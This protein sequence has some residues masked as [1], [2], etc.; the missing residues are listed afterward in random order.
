MIKFIEL[1]NFIIKRIELQDE[2]FADGDGIRVK[3]H[4]THSDFVNKNHSWYTAKMLKK[5]A[6]TLLTP[7]AKPVV[8]NHSRDQRDTIGRVHDAKFITSPG[9]NGSSGYI[10]ALADIWGY[11]H[12]KKVENKNYLTVSI[13]LS[14]TAKTKITCNICGEDITGTQF[15]HA[16]QRGEIYDKKECYWIFDNEMEIDHIAFVPE[17]ADDY[18][19][20]INDS[21]QAEAISTNHEVSSEIVHIEKID[22]DK[23]ALEVEK[24]EEN[25]KAP[26]I[27]E[28]K[29]EEPIVENKDDTECWNGIEE[30][31]IKEIIRLDTLLS[32][33]DKLSPEK[34]KQL[35]DSVF[36]GPHR[37]FPIDT[38]DRARSALRLLPKSTFGEST[39]AKI[40]TCII[41]KQKALKCGIGKTKDEITLDE[42]LVRDDINNYINTNYYL[43]KDIDTVGNNVAKSIVADLK[44]SVDENLK[45]E[46]DA[47][48]NDYT[49]LVDE[50]LDLVNR[51][52]DER[53]KVLQLIKLIANADIKTAE[54]ISITNEEIENFTDTVKKTIEANERNPITD[55][56]SQSPA[57][58]KKVD[59]K[60][61]EEEDNKEKE[62]KIINIS[63]LSQSER[64][65]ILTQNSKTN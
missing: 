31:D 30:K 36:C 43:K 45:A 52:F 56:I 47:I 2:K 19:M 7:F 4:I 25:S 38:C 23:E 57:E 65:A 50:H 12:V 59:N 29:K 62:Y 37:S 44:I 42:I 8:V 27:V 39:K 1:D 17:P 35:P 49:S 46:F 20:I 26:A 15:E 22:N 40:K 9:K 32:I 16:H 13:S 14:S 64:I 18:A 11:E 60:D 3:M 24:K 55:P 10:E 51:M 5:A 33:E 53:V 41:K 21:V 6:A 28:P 34:R 54:E 48:S 63:E 61:D 58:N